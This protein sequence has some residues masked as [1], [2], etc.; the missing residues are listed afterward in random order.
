MRILWMAAV[1]GVFSYALVWLAG[2]MPE[3]LSLPSDLFRYAPGFV[4]G[5]MVMQAGIRAIPR[6]IG[7]ILA[8]GLVWFLMF[9]LASH[10][11][12]EYDQ[13][14]LLAC[15]VAG[16]LG[17][18]LMSLT[19]RLLWPRRLS[20]LAVLMAFV[21]GVLGGSLIGQG[22]LEP[23]GSFLLQALMLLGFIVWQTGVGGS[24]LLVDELGEHEPHV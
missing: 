5:L 17:A 7:V 11:V 21:S 23:D 16:G 10:L 15:A 19:V 13:S 14:T 2:D 9:R 22:L 3:W 20:L 4:F 1:S 6:R 8:T 24:L 18:W 12:T